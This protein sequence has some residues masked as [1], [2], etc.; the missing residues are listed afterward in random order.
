MNIDYI[1]LKDLD[2]NESSIVKKVTES[3]I[4]K[5]ERGLE[6]S[7]LVIHIK[8][9]KAVG[10]GTKKYSI[11]ARIDSPKV[12]VRAKAFDWDLA[13]AIHK[14][15]AKLKNEIEHKFKKEGKERR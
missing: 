10:K 7:V 4:K 2:E 12:I 8:T 1:K 5:I 9:H 3:L 6:E 11:H 14:L 13:K 15:F